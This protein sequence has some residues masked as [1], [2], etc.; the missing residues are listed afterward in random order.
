MANLRPLINLAGKVI[1]WGGGGRMMDAYWGPTRLTV[2]NY[3]RVNYINDPQFH[4]LKEIVSV[5]PEMFERHMAFTKQHFNVIDVQTLSDFVEK[6]RA[7][8]PRSCLIT[9][10]DGYLD[11]YTYAYPV[12]K[13]YGLPAV[14]FLM[15]SA[16]DDPKVPWWDEMAYYF[17]RTR[18][19]S[20]DLPLIGTHSLATAQDRDAVRDVLLHKLKEIPQAQKEAE[21]KR[22]GQAVEVDVPPRDR[23]LFVTWDQVRE[24]VADGVACQPHTVNHP[25]LTRIDAAQRREELKGSFAKIEEE[26]KRPAIAF[27][28]PNGMP[29]DYNQDCMQA[30]REVGCKVA[31][32]MTPDLASP[33]VVKQHP[34]EI[35][36]VGIWWAD[37]YEMFGLKAMGLVPLAKRLRGTH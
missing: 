15:T 28:Y 18:K 14:I 31:F 29:T 37:T 1:F 20:A 19:P 3:H 34:Y 8:P 27:A 23:N 25:I 6:G 36:R 9:F 22:I 24:M 5:T 26:T 12:L 35:P 16:M 13:K 11:N 17:S 4:Y 33:N 2:L 7:L 32:T 10:D 21:L 30:L